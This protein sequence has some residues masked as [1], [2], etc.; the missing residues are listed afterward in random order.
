MLR[1]SKTTTI[2]Y[3][4]P[5]IIHIQRK[6][7]ANSNFSLEF[8]F[9]DV[10]ERLKHRF[11]F[12]LIIAS[13]TSN[14]LWNRLIN[15]VQ[16]CIQQGNINHVTGDI[17]YVTYL[18]RKRGTILTILDCGF[19]NE[20]N[21]FKRWIFKFFWLTLPVQ[22]ARYITAISTAT[23]QDIIRYTGCDEEKITV[24]PVAVDE[25]YKPFYKAFNTDQPRLLQ[26]GTAVNKNVERLIE[27][28]QGLPCTLVVIG[29]LTEA[30]TKMLN[31]LNIRYENRMN[32]TQEEVYEEY[33]RAD[34]VTFVSTF[35]GFGMPIIEANC[36]E[37]PVIAGNNSSMPEVGADAAYFVE[38]TNV[39]QIRE[40]ILNLINDSGLRDNL[41]SKGRINK[42]R[43]S[44]ET[45]ANRYGAIYEEALKSSS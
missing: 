24:I 44:N 23:K 4:R 33:C 20:P 22:R 25:I 1:N 27:A 17:H 42:T 8:I 19:M 38:A 31:D 32:L 10:R 39:E 43:F 9:T 37:R 26:I 11:D 35:E 45:I 29:R 15:I 3:D 12:S 28:I 5:V 34:I 2:M 36:V 13:K 21:R 41:I 30:Q 6:R 18:L 14:G 16:V 7:R 40:G